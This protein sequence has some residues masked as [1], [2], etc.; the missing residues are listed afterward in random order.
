M[1]F[2]KSAI[3]S[4]A[5]LA[6]FASANAAMINVGGVN[7]DPDYSDSGEV[8]FLGKFNFRQWYTTTISTKATGIAAGN[9]GS[10][11]GIGAVSTPGGD[12]YLQG[13]GEFYRV[14]EGESAGVPIFFMDAG[15]EL[16]FAFGGIKLNADKVS[17]NLDD[18]WAQLRVNSTSP[19]FSD[20]AG[21]DAEVA[22]AQSGLLW[23]DLDIATLGFVQGG[24][25]N[26][27]V[28]ADLDIIGGAAAGN[29]FPQNGLIYS[30][31]AFFTGSAAQQHS[32]GG[33]GTL[34]GNTIPEPA[35]LALVGLGLVGV[36]LARRKYVK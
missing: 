32:T 15:L 33:N 5:L 34:Q 36:G 8:D 17:F 7:W 9:Y 24:V 30:A 22:D 23:L 20:P 4:V 35:S 29:F 28:S 14:N 25:T 12:Y 16:T 2:L 21:G 27:L 11:V 18:A 10:A 31:Q 6:C 13:V 1:K 3:T 19:N 26:G